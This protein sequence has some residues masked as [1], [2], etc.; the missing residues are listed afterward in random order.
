MTGYRWFIVLLLLFHPCIVWGACGGSSTQSPAGTFTVYD[1]SKDCVSAAVDDAQA[2]G[3]GGI[4]QLKSDDATWSAELAKTLTK[5]ITIQGVSNSSPNITMDA[6]TKLFKLKADGTVRATIK[7]MKLSLYNGGVS[8]KT[9][10][11][12]YG[13]SRYKVI[14]NIHFYMPVAATS[15]R[16]V[17]FG[18]NSDATQ[19][20][21]LIHKCIFE[22]TGTTGQGI[23]VFG[24]TAGSYNYWT[25]NPSFGTNDNALYIENN[26]FTFTALADGAF[27]AYAGA[28][29]VFRYNNVSGT[30]LGWHGN[31]SSSGLHSAE[32]YNNAFTSAASTHGIITYARG[33]T[34][35]VYNNTADSSFSSTMIIGL[36]RSCD[37]TGL[38][39]HMCDGG[40]TYDANTDVGYR[41]YQQPGSTG[42]D[43]VTQWP[44]SAWNNVKDGSTAITWENSGQYLGAFCVARG[45]T[46]GKDQSY[47]VIEGRDYIED[48]T[49]EGV[50]S[51]FCTAWWDDT[52]NRGK[53]NGSAI[54]TY[55]CPHPLS[56]YAGYSC[57]TAIAGTGGYPGTGSGSGET[58]SGPVWTLT[59]G[60]VGTLQ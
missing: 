51:D 46:D 27:D 17:I 58:G 10:V 41:C 29:I 49:C 23:G 19:G 40:G 22:N 31:D 55:T 12:M 24:N 37:A 15:G 21:G 45:R 33:G 6:N 32:I 2:Y 54:G 9:C 25:G 42:T 47:Y 60:A 36:F 34:S 14:E 52:N 38:D 7:D 50:T 4:V 11:Q 13:T 8:T 53:A 5:N 3:D 48:D 59:G 57:N 44:M 56:G 28:D 18:A 1:N 39:A 30:G 35:I 26:T 20:G 43:G 16:G